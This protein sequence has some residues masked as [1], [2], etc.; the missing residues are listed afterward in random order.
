MLL[1]HL[2]GE[3]I[4]FIAKNPL[5]EGTTTFLEDGKI[6]DVKD[7]DGTYVIFDG[8]KYENNQFRIFCLNIETPS[9][10]FLSGMRNLLH[11]VK[12]NNNCKMG[13]FIRKWFKNNGYYPLDN[14]LGPVSFNKN[15][16]KN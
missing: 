3:D 16:I 4:V 6:V 12:G 10:E 7:S 8:V 1:K 14:G 13:K 2:I 11:T 9:P 5:Y 15:K